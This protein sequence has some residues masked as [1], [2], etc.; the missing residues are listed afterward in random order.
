MWTS[1][2][3]WTLLYTLP[4]WRLDSN[5]RLK[6][7]STGI[8]DISIHRYVSVIVSLSWPSPLTHRYYPYRSKAWLAICCCGR[9]ARTTGVFRHKV[10]SLASYQ[11]LTIPLCLWCGNGIEPSAQE[12]SGSLLYQLSYRTIICSL[13]VD[14]NSRFTILSQQVNAL[15]EFPVSYNHNIFNISKNLFSLFVLQ[16]YIIFFNLPNLF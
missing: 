7:S 6:L 14:S 1:F 9:W 5:Q 16:K 2:S 11:L 12:F 4:Y 13:V 3:S 8:D 15:Y 10:M